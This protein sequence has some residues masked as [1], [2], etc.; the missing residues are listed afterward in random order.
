MKMSNDDEE[1]GFHLGLGYPHPS[2]GHKSHRFGSTDLW[3][4]DA[5]VKSPTGEIIQRAGV[6]VDCWFKGKEESDTGWLTEWLTKHDSEEER[7]QFKKTYRDL[8][9]KKEE[10]E[11]ELSRLNA[12]LR[13]TMEFISSIARGELHNYHEKYEPLNLPKVPIV[14]PLTKPPLPSLVR[15]HTRENEQSGFLAM[16]QNAPSGYP[17]SVPCSGP[18]PDD[19]FAQRSRD[20]KSF[21]HGFTDRSRGMTYRESTQLLH[22]MQCQDSVSEGAAGFPPRSTFCC[23]SY[24]RGLPGR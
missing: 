12:N 9:D 2:T 22:N 3:Q 11:K 10:Q 23:G 8:W 4:M 20:T 7:Q 6:G 19:V 1:T 16:M 15:N 17:S 13:A 21:I 5:Y 24:G 14:E 18:F